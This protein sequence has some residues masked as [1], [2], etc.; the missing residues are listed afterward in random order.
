[1]TENDF[2]QMRRLAVQLLAKQLGI[3]A[4]PNHNQCPFLKAL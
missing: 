2:L 4:E 3:I 1:M